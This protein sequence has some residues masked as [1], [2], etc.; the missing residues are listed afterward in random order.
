MSDH[1]AL[2]VLRA[3]FMGLETEVDGYTCKLGQDEKGRD[4]FCFAAY[5]ATIGE[6]VLYPFDVSLDAFL[7]ICAEMPTEQIE[8]LKAG[9]GLNKI[10]AGLPKR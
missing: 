10:K 8:R 2:I 9:I 1:N 3:L 6:S 7:T 5:N 4:R